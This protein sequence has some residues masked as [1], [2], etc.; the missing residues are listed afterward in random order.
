MEILHAFHEGSLKKDIMSFYQEEKVE[1]HYF[2]K[3]LLN[4]ACGQ[5]ISVDLQKCKKRGQDLLSV[6]VPMYRREPE[7]KAGIK[8]QKNNKVK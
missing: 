5:I 6:I 2:E 1:L 3:L 4:F 7:G 8:Y